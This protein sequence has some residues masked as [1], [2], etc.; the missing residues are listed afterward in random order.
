MF[1][2]ELSDGERQKAMIARMIA[3]ESPLMIM[4]EPT[5]FLDISGK[6][7]VISLLLK[8][9]RKSKTIVFSTHDFN[10]AISQAD[11]I[12]LL[13]EN[14]LIEGSPEDLMLCGA[15]DNLFDSSVV[16]FNHDDGNFTFRNEHHGEIFIHGT[17][18][19]KHWTEKAVIRAGFS[20]AEKKT[21]RY[22]EIQSD[23]K[24]QWILHTGESTTGFDSIYE[25]L[26]Y[27]R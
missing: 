18:L 16:R 15:F 23:E 9:T 6:Y 19:T 3:Q 25:L 2:S 26:K 27:L 10:V 24:K 12:W 20:V 11:K 13:L 17:G 7:D 8:L 21:S 14:R 22:I 5:A 1:I 4:D